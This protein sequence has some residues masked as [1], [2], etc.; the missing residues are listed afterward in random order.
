VAGYAPARPDLPRHPAELTALLGVNASIS[1]LFAVQVNTLTYVLFSIVGLLLLRLIFRK[2]WIA[3]LIH[4]VL[5]V[6]VFVSAWPWGFVTI[7]VNGLFW[8]VFF[9]R[10][11]WVSVAVGTFTV[12]L[13]NGFPLTA[14]PSVW[15]RQAPIIAALVC[16]TLAIYGF[17]V[18]LAGRP[19]FKDLLVE[20]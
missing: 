3:V 6:F 5:Y 13:L 2:T 19:V 10:F 15:Y 14:D 16:G 11:G 17:K 4:W 8:Y 18:S 9:F 1:E 12:D 20:D 7:P